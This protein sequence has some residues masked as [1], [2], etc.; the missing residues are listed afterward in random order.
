V[1]IVLVAHGYPP[2]L[3]GGTERCVRTLARALVSR[4]HAVTVVAGTLANDGGTHTS[5]DV[6]PDSL[7]R[8][9]VVRLS[10][11]DLYTDNWQK[12]ASSTIPQRFREILREARPDVVHVHHWLRLSRDLVACAA[13]ERVPAVVTLHDLWT[14]CLVA[15]RVRP[16]TLA[17]CDVPLSAM[18][19]LD[20]AQ[21][22]P[23]RTPWVP[24]EQ[25]FLALG[26]HKSDLVREMHLARALLVPTRAHGDTLSRLLGDDGKALTFELLASRAPL[27]RRRA[28]APAR[29]DRLVLA[30][31]GHHSVVKGFD[32]LLDALGDPRLLGRVE[33][34]VAGTFVEPAFEQAMRARAGGPAVRFH[35]A[36]DAEHLHD[37]VVARAHAFVT[38][39]RARESSG[40]VLDEARA[41]GLPSVLPRHPAFVER[42]GGDT[43]LFEPGD[44]KSLA[45]T[46]ARLL[47]EPLLLPALAQ[48]VP[49]RV[50]DAAWIRGDIDRLLVIYADAARAGAPP[51]P[52]DV[53]AWYGPRMRA[54][55]EEEWDRRIAQS[56]PDP[57]SP[58]VTTQPADS[59]AARA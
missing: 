53:D 37:H 4:G 12:S 26:A 38:A 2:E 44:A 41:L 16:D 14:T 40:L 27:P 36:Y 35:G 59:G 31:F 46:L 34:E 32:L 20:C 48:Q 19:C 45:G 24:L 49:A 23:P 58:D 25:Q 29:S 22:V 50:D 30:T 42:A 57:S 51:A 10:R 54:F 18:P 47:D 55:A 15:F 43:L 3:S 9:R 28:D 6:D 11:R 13:A 17:P 7:A 39:T 5:E 56:R 8:V 33:L 1:R 52:A 21:K